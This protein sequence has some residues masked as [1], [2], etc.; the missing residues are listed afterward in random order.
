[1]DAIPRSDTFLT[2]D[3]HETLLACADVCPAWRIRA[4]AII[5]RDMDLMSRR[6]VALFVSAVRNAS[7]DR[8]GFIKSLF[9]SRDCSI[10]GL[11]QMILSR[12]MD[13]LMTPLP[14]LYDLS[15]HNC[16]VDLGPRILRMGLPLFASLTSL[17]CTGCDFDTYRTMLDVVWSCRGLKKLLLE[18]CRFRDDHLT[19]ENAA[20]LSAAQRNSRGCRNLEMLTVDTNL[21]ATALPGDVFGSS[22]TS[23]KLSV[24]HGELTTQTSMENLGVANAP[25]KMRL[26]GAGG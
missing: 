17:A 19:A 26:S 14:R 13:L 15:L 8:V 2:P 12:V 18:R 21:T 23:L 4:N 9:L 3:E 1:M 22:L 11:G 20:R 7:P 5:N 6:A 16:T 10:E 25:P 24:G